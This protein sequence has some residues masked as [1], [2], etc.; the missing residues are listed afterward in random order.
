MTNGAYGSRSLSGHMMD[1]DDTVS[2]GKWL[3]TPDRIGSAYGFYSS[4]CS[5]IHHGHH[6]Y[7]PYRRSKKGY[8]P[9]DFKEA[10][11]PTFDGEPKKPKEAKAWLLGINKF[12]ELHDYTKNMKTMIVIFNLKGKS[13]IWWE[14][15]K[16]VISIKMEELS[17]HEFNSSQRM[18][19][20]IRSS[21]S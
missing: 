1:K 7:H 15:V 18:M 3:D 17:W 2:G 12:F 8:F 21:M 9:Y 4:F 20:R 16:R 19:E 10:K 11:P 14:D 5:D 13:K 6:L